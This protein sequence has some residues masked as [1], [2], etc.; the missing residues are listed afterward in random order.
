MPRVGENVSEVLI[1][2]L[3]AEPGQMIN[4][5]DVLARVET[6]KA[7]VDV[8]A[9]VAGRFVEFLVVVDQE[10]VPGDHF[11]VIETQ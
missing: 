2:D 9:E 1:V 4:I 7:T 11:A 5:G 8:V 3:V 10:L 6:D